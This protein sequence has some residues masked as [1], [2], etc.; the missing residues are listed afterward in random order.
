[1]IV[2][3]YAYSASRVNNKTH[4]EVILKMPHLGLFGRENCHAVLIDF[5]RTRRV[6]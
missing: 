5:T 3:Q 6:G 2:I 4:C 1:M